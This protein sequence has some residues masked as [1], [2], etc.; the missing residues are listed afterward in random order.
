MNPVMDSQ[1]QQPD[2]TPNS[3]TSPPLRQSH[4]YIEERLL[5]ALLKSTE[6]HFVA[7]QRLATTTDGKNDYALVVT[8]PDETET[9]RFVLC[10][11][12]DKSI[13][14]FKNLEFCR[15]FIQRLKP[16]LKRFYTI[17]NPA[18]EELAMEETP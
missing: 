15:H 9:E 1:Q 8:V 10:T 14:R 11:S 3:A 16:D 12:P 5:R 13:R 18:F 6:I 2:T 7:F 17:I 4:Y